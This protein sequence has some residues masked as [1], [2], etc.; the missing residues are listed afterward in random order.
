MEVGWT[1]VLTIN[2]VQVNRTAHIASLFLIFIYYNI[3]IIPAACFDSYVTKLMKRCGTNIIHAYSFSFIMIVIS[4]TYTPTYLN[5]ILCY[6]IVSC[7]AFL[8]F[9]HLLMNRFLIILLNIC[10]QL[11][12]IIICVTLLFSSWIKVMKY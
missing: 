5:S 11:C 1:Q 9:A 8:L 7:M 12:G 4:A 10:G 2:D 3:M 6:L